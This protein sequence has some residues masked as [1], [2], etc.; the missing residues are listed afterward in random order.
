[1]L[2]F[3]VVHTDKKN[4]IIVQ[5]TQLFNAIKTRFVSS[6]VLFNQRDSIEIY[7]VHYFARSLF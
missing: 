4:I 3:L 2:S 6:V 7:N 1:M 5:I